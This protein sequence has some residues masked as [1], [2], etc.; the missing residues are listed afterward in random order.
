MLQGTIIVFIVFGVTLILSLPLGFLVALMRLSRFKVLSRIVQLYIFVMRGTPLLLQMIVI[1]FGLPSLG[2]VFDRLPS[3]LIAFVLNYTA[4]YAEIFR[5]GIQSIDRGQYEACQV[6]GF[7]KMTMYRK[8]ILPQVTKIVF[9]S[10]A[11]EIITL[12]KDTSL[13]YVLGL[14]DILRLAQI[15]TT[16]SGSLIPLM[17]AGIIY[18]LLT[19]I[20]TKVL[21]TI[22][23]KLNYYN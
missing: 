12:V 1:F 7:D 17:H 9:P 4:Y 13:V 22:E 14:N 11:N 6:L 18:L 21:N 19:G 16:R 20:L 15:A 10:V 2:I 8:I 5:G 23:N 3:C